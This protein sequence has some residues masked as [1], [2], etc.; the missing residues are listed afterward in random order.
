MC[1]YSKSP[2]NSKYLDRGTSPKDSHDLST[3]GEMTQC[4]DSVTIDHSDLN[5]FGIFSV[6]S[7]DLFYSQHCHSSKYL[8]GC[9]SLKHKKYCIL[10]KQYTQNEYE[11]LIDKIK[12]QMDEIPFVDKNNIEYKFGEFFPSEL[13]P[14]GYNETV[15]ME[16][17]PLLKKQVLDKHFNW[18]DNIQKTTDKGTLAIDQIPDSIND[19]SDLILDE[20][21]SCVDCGRN[22]KII[23]NEL[24]FYHKMKIP[25]PRRC[26]HCRNILR[27]NRTNPFKL[28]HRRCMCEKEN[29]DH[30]GKC[31]VEFET[32]Y[33]PERPEIIYCERCYQNEVY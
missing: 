31:Q 13:S 33:A 2:E 1:F 19:V 3:A 28:W 9:I 12:K 29:H 11:E 10:N 27:V 24:I 26:F 7:Q 32:S 14:F 21:L 20:I 5:R 30:Q 23:P 6:K 25:I 18:Q 4:Y 15:A 16:Y 8:F 17:V 22:Y